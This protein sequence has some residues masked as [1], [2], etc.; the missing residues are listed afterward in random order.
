MIKNLVVVPVALTLLVSCMKTTAGIGDKSIFSP[1]DP[2]VQIHSPDTGAKPPVLIY[3]HGGSGFLSS[4]RK[5]VAMFRHRGFAT[6]SFDAYKMNGLDPREVNRHYSNYHKQS[7][8][9]NV[10]KGAY[11]YALTR[12]DWDARNIFLYGQSNGG[13]VA[14]TLPRFV[15]DASHI[16][17]ILAEGMSSSG[18]PSQDLKIPTRLYYG[19]QDT[20][21]GDSP[22]WIRTRHNPVSVEDWVAECRKTGTDVELDL[23]ENAGHSFHYHGGFMKKTSE[24]GRSGFSFTAHLG[25]YGSVIIQYEKDVFEFVDSRLVQ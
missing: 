11:E 5:R 24:R 20:W 1:T 4:D 22:M 19:K 16:R 7:L 8:T 6:I 15:S 3:A 21:G 23:Y 25:A 18:L 13:R 9:L 14:I 2:L 17:G 12:K 10:A